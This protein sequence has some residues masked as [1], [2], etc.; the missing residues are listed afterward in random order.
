M[1]KVVRIVCA[2]VS[3]SVSVSVCAAA[4]K[5]LQHISRRIYGLR[6]VCRHI[7]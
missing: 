1:R 7:A 2:N 6:L 4:T 3:A 5:I